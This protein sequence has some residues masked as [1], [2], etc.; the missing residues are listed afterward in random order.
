MALPAAQ[1]SQAGQQKE[2]CKA[3]M[4]EYRMHTFS[5]C[6]TRQT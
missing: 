3:C 4:G 1:N 5:M 2:T 6:T